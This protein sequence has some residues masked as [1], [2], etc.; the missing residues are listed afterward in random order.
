MLTVIPIRDSCRAHATIIQ[1]CIYWDD[2]WEIHCA[3]AWWLDVNGGRTLLSNQMVSAI[4]ECAI[5]KD[6]Y[7]YIYIY[8]I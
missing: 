4:H 8:N 1:T 6:R 5:P 3:G 7:S 2:H